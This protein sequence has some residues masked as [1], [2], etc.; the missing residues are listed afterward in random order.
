MNALRLTLPLPPTQKPL[1]CQA[2]GKVIKRRKYCSVKCRAIA[3]SQKAKEKRMKKPCLNCGKEMSLAPWQENRKN[4]SRKC[5][6]SSKKA[7]R[8]KSN[9]L[10][11]GKQFEITQ[12]RV[13]HRT[14]KYCSHRCKGI[15]LRIKMPNK[16]TSI[17]IKTAEILDKLGVNYETQKR[18]K[19]ICI[20]DFFIPPDLIVECDGEYWH[21]FKK[22]K[23]VNKDVILGFNGYR[24]LRLTETEIKK[25]PIVCRNKIRKALR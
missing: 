22:D 25:H 5:A 18:L 13:R 10:V 15:A 4:C 11:C 9:C 20:A 8:T 17:E 7:R 16:N 6:E 2:C 1:I 23:D 21:S 12:W 14:G 3:D 19:G 24:V